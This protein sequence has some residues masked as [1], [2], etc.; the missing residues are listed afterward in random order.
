MQP[1]NRRVFLAILGGKM[2]AVVALL[3]GIKFFAS[4]FDTGAAA[5]V[6]HRAN[7][8]VNPINTMWTLVTAFLVF[9]MQAGFMALEVGFAR[10][11]ETVNIMLECVFDTCL[12][13]VL[14]WAFGFAFMFG[15]GNG[16]IGHQFFMLHGA[17]A[18]YGTSGVAFL[19][20]WLFQFA[21]ADTCSTITSGAMVGRTGFKGDILYS[22]GVS[23]FIYPIFG[24]WVWGPGGW[25]GNMT[26]SQPPGPHTQ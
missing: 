12:C 7:D 5:Q 18:T 26:P 19:A 13:G 10:S 3:V 1:E 8:F 2:V 14:W 16:L 21:F 24:H 17:P 22:F 6:A 9:F 11:R 25:L 15:E 20:F 23:G 4:Y